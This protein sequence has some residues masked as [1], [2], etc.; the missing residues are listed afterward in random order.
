MFQYRKITVILFFSIVVISIWASVYFYFNKYIE[1]H[2]F[3]GPIT[4]KIETDDHKELTDVVVKY[5]TAVYTMESARTISNET[6]VV[7]TG[8]SITMER[9]EVDSIPSYFQVTIIH[10]LYKRLE[11][12]IIR[13]NLPSDEHGKINFGVIKLINLENVFSD[14]NYSDNI[15]EN[16]MGYHLADVE[17]Y[18]LPTMTGKNISFT[19]KN[20]TDN[21]LELCNRAFILRNVEVCN[22]RRKERIRNLF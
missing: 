6:Y 4:F 14:S 17:R 2:Y 21:I 8:M 3:Y 10:P 19:G 18:Y 7:R 11:K 20:Y 9:H 5:H 1:K 12:K 16:I 22:K 13:K 15:L